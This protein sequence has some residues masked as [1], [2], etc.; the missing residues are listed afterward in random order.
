VNTNARHS[1][2]GQV[3]FSTHDVPLWTPVSAWRVVKQLHSC[4]AAPVVGIE[5][6]NGEKQIRFELP[7]YLL[8]SKSTD[9]LKSAALNVL[10]SVFL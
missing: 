1:F 6:P 9:S 2:F 7:C 8:F 5:R 3:A 4:I 10:A